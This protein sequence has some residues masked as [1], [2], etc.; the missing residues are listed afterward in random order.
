M[1]NFFRLGSL[2]CFFPTHTHTRA[3]E[4]NKT[5]ISQINGKLVTDFLVWAPRWP[6][7]VLVCGSTAIKGHNFI[8]S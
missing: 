5:H 2:P 1:V 6:Q 8:G 7:A 3:R 4:Q